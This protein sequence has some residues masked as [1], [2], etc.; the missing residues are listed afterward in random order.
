MEKSRQKPQ[1]RMKVLSEAL[2]CNKY[3]SEP[4]LHSCGILISTSFTQEYGRVLLAPR[5]KVGNGEDFFPRNV[6]VEIPLGTNL[7]KGSLDS[8]LLP[9]TGGGY[10]F[11]GKIPL[12]SLHM[13]WESSPNFSLGQRAEIMTTVNMNSCFLKFSCLNEDK[14]ISVQLPCNPETVVK[15]RKCHC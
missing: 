12:E 6:G 9:S 10:C 11:W 13:S 15:G 7:S 8:N 3:D 1:E 4:L 14:C 2:K 5:L